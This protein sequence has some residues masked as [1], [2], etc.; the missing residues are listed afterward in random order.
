MRLER[1]N[2][3]GLVSCVSVVWCLALLYY[4]SM[5]T[6]IDM[7]LVRRVLIKIKDIY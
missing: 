5:N 4:G 3:A 2:G 6:F 7:L 1:K